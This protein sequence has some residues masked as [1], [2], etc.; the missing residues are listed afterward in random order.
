LA[1][2]IKFERDK[3]EPFMVVANPFIENNLKFINELLDKFAVYTTPPT[4]PL[5]LLRNRH[6]APFTVPISTLVLFADIMAR[7]FLPASLPRLL[8]SA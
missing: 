8:L 5:S 3:K 2:G 7:P 1:N 4:P 6:L